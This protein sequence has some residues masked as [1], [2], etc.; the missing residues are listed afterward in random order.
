[1]AFARSTPIFAVNLSKKGLPRPLAEAVSPH[2]HRLL[3]FEQFNSVYSQLPQCAPE[4]FSRAFLDALHVRVQL[5]ERS[6]GTIPAEGPLIVVANHPL[7]L[8]DGMVVE[9]LLRSVRSDVTVMA[10]SLMAVIPEYRDLWLFVGR[11]RS[12]SKR[13][14]SVRSLRE[15]VQ[16]LA[17]G[18]ALVVFPAGR[19][20]RFQWRRWSV[21]DRP[22]SSHIAAL[23]RRTGAPVLPIYLH[24]PGSRM[25]QLAGMFFPLLQNVR[26]VGA[27]SE[28][29]DRIL[30]ATIGRVIQPGELAGY[31]ADDEATAFL[32]RE[33]EKLARS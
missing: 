5:H 32:R 24:G 11:P 33:T 1:M 13:K 15:S 4:N 12:R 16:R 23:A 8:L 27:V 14:L 20:A 28:Y 7:G 22:W 6:R 26:A 25:S 19:V 30:H 21:A 2:L 18:G 10:H 9:S 3:G 31:A 17:R 29:Q